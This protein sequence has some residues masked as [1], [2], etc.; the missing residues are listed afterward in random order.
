VTTVVFVLLP[1]VHLLDL[2][3]PA[4]AFFTAGDHGHPYDLRYVSGIE[5]G[6]PGT[7]GAPGPDTGVVA[8]AQGLPLVAEPTGRTSAPTTSSSCPAGASAAS[9]PPGPG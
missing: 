2:A 3:G 5:P 6:G 9:G 7:S 4:Q 1:G 8:S